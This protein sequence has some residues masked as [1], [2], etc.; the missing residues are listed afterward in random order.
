MRASRARLACVVIVV[1]WALAW[2]ALRSA[3]PPA[4]VRVA[5]RPVQ[6]AS[7]TPTPTAPPKE[8]AAPPPVPA[9]P[10]TPPEPLT[11]VESAA[12]AVQR[13]DVA[14]GEALL[15]GAGSFPPL[16]ASYEA[17]G[18][19]HAYAAA[20]HRLGARFVVVERRHILGEIDPEG[21]LLGS[22][23]PSGRFS[24]RARDYS[25]EPAL[26]PARA[27][28]RARWGM[29]STVM[30]LVP[31]RVDAVL[32]GAVARR[33]AERGRRP[34]EYRALEARYARAR[35]GSL[36][37]HVERGTR[38]DGSEEEIHLVLDLSRIAREGA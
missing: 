25:D 16:H 13:E 34:D 36:T 12:S 38:L 27:R 3:A 9:A 1:L 21:N 8:P 2:S 29:G 6:R 31:H 10:V 37:L 26:A 17:L 14:R 33:L 11:S 18:S 7:D 35:H 20:M 19:F 32:F 22:S 30:M 24:P 15:Q 23:P 5:V 4:P 28:A